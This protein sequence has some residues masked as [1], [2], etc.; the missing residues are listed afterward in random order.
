LG[1]TKI[2]IKYHLLRI[3]LST[4]H[5]GIATGKGLDKVRMV[6]FR[7]LSTCILENHLEKKEAD[8]HA[9][10]FSDASWIF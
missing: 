8:G 3:E 9:S 5:L 4:Q 1:K 7:K 6:G 10:A 2:V